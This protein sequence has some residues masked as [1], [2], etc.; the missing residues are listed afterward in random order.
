MFNLSALSG[1]LNIHNDEQINA[2][3]LLVD[4]QVRVGDG[5]DLSPTRML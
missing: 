5:L 3:V 2:V 1:G 4:L